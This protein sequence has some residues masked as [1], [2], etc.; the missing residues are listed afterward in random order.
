MNKIDT[1]VLI[2]VYNEENYI[3]PTIQCILN[4]TYENFELWIIDDGSTDNTWQKIKSFRDK[5]ISIFHFDKNVGITTRLNWVVPRITTKYLARMDSHNLADPS[6][7][8]KQRDFLLIHP[9]VM[10]LGSNFIAVDPSGKEMFRSK[11]PCTYREIKNKLLEKNIFRHGSLFFQTNI[12]EK[13]GNYNLWSEY[14]QDYDLMLRITA[15]FPVANLPD[16]LITAIYRPENMMQKHCFRSACE[17]FL[18]QV[19]GLTTYGYPLWQYIYLIRGIGYAGKCFVLMI[20]NNL[21]T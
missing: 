11:L 1:T 9:E 7:L 12:F 10:V 19:K 6:R 2:S 15:K 13:V 5:R 14:A 20:N 8:Q 18:A 16:Y 17:A 3:G 4:Q 21:K